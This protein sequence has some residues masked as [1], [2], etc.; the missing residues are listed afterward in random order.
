MT[1]VH[2]DNFFMLLGEGI[3]FERGYQKGVP[4]KRFFAA[5]GS[6]K[7]S[8]KTVADRYKHAAF[9]NKHYIFEFVTSDETHYYFITC[10]IYMIAQVAR[11]LLSRV[12]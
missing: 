5:I 7:P 8:V 9:H 12:T 6:Y 11:L 4:L 3:P 2:H 1:L 10:C